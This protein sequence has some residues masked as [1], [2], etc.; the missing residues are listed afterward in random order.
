MK[1][2]P[3]QTACGGSPCTPYT[4][5]GSRTG[6]AHKDVKQHFVWTA[7]V[8]ANAYD[9][10]HI[11]QSDHSPSESF[12]EDYG[13]DST[14][15]YAHLCPDDIGWPVTGERFFGVALKDDRFVW[16]GPRNPD[17]VK[18]HFMSIFGQR[19]AV[20]GNMFAELDTQENIETTRTKWTKYAGEPFDGTALADQVALPAKADRVRGYAELVE[21]KHGRSGTLICDLAQNSATQPSASPLMPRP[22]T[23]CEHALFD[24]FDNEKV[25]RLFTAAEL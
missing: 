5:R 1:Y 10:L 23:R 20:D 21:L 17:A 6:L 19:P 18:T 3:L 14:V 12:V 25:G 11:E 8:K 7:E 24:K 9:I 15:I 2:R 16:V 22:T 13:E 4:S